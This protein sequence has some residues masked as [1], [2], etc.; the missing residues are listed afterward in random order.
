M[1]Y[2]EDLA[3]HGGAE[4]HQ[5]FWMAHPLV[6]EAINR[7]VSGDPQVWPTTWFRRAFAERLPFRNALSVGCG[8]GDLERDLAAN[9]AVTSIIGIDVV[10]A[11]L[12]AAR[13]LAGSLPIRYE[14]ADARDYLRAHPASFD[15]I[16]FHGSLHHF[17]RVDEIMRLTREAL[18]QDGVL[19]VDEY[20]GPSMHQWNALRLLPLNIAYYRLPRALRR[21]R[22][23]RA[24]RNPED[25]TEQIASADIVPA[26]ERHFRTVARR[27]YGGNL[28]AVIYPN[29]EKN[30]SRAMLDAAVA[31]LIGWEDDMLRAGARSHH[32]VIVATR[33]SGWP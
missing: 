19:F 26:I 32:T 5:H 17:E 10:S 9:G 7:R 28:L 31:R 20:V 8:A 13:S 15:A 16:F 29:L 30:V 2:W 6:R 12:E 24:P 25:P 1:T 4:C 14:R 18:A 21:P 22:L 33:S 27:D 3:H 23:V 11:P